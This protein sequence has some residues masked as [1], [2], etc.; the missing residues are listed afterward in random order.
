MKNSPELSSRTPENKLRKKL[1]AA[2]LGVL[3]LGA[4]L[5]IVKT[6][7]AS[8]SIKAVGV[9]S[10]QP[11]YARGTSFEKDGYLP[12][13]T[14]GYKKG[15]TITI[16]ARCPVTNY[17][18]CLDHPFDQGSKKSPEIFVDNKTTE[19]LHIEGDRV[20]DKFLGIPYWGPFLDI[21]TVPAGT[22]YRN[23]SP[24]ELSKIMTISEDRFPGAYS[25]GKTMEILSKFGETTMTQVLQ[26]TD[27]NF[28]IS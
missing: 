20:S 26:Q 6:S 10:I 15:Q 13:D 1:A 27:P 25:N 8:A 18:E 28:K 23:S 3:A 22:T 5:G 7:P 19:I 2:A 14:F 9:E 24:S 4:S 12:I 21:S 17:Q 11:S 16:F